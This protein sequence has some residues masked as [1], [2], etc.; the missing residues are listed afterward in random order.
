MTADI[1]LILMGM[2]VLLLVLK[3]RN[4]NLIKHGDKTEG[5][6]VDYD[7][8]FQKN[9]TNKFPVVRFTTKKEELFTITS[10]D[11]FLPARVKKGK[12]VTILYN[13]DNPKEFTIQLPNEKLM[14]GT[15]VTGAIVF[16]VTGLIL[17]LNELNVIHVFKK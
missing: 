9:D 4:K 5:V 11:G 1:F 12:K 6:I 13:P 10:P 14:F 7:S 15:L 17:L 2:T 8:S 3:S 16:T